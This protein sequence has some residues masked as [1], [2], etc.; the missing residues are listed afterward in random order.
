[1]AKKNF[2]VK[3]NRTIKEMCVMNVPAENALKAR[4]IAEYMAENEPGEVNWN[5]DPN[6]MPGKITTVI[7]VDDPS[8]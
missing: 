4:H 7:V 8:E 6:S 1:M 2:T 5:D 3:L